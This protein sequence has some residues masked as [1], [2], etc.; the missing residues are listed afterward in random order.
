MAVQVVGVDLAQQGSE[1]TV[2]TVPH[3]HYLASGDRVR[4]GGSPNSIRHHVDLVFSMT[5][6]SIKTYRRPSKGY[7]KHLRRMK[8]AGK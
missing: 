8:A 4:I 3:R 6:F 5:Q 7:R 1:R 2:C